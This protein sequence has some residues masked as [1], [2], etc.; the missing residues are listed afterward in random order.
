[1]PR[2][3]R[4]TGPPTIW[5]LDG[6]ARAS[7]PVARQRATSLQEDGSSLVPSLFT[8]ATSMPEEAPRSVGE[9]VPPRADTAAG[10]SPAPVR[11]DAATTAWSSAARATSP[12]PPAQLDAPPAQAR[13]RAKRTACAASWEDCQRESGSG[14]AVP[15]LEARPCA[16]Q[17]SSRPCRVLFK[18]GGSPDL[19]DGRLAHAARI[20]SRRLT[21]A[22]LV[23]GEARS[24]RRP[25]VAWRTAAAT[26]ALAGATTGRGEGAGRRSTHALPASRPRWCASVIRAALAS[27]PL[28]MATA[29]TSGVAD[30]ASKTASRLWS[31]SSA[32]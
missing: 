13:L 21:P 2:G 19:H 27:H 8:T 32:L 6:A 23:A 9:G 16:A 18:A 25:R 15:L 17:P 5:P 7:T 30:A 20:A 26:V 31:A 4:A 28:A 12:D 29:E 10:T 24:D 3:A 22:E 1:M 11:R 14:A